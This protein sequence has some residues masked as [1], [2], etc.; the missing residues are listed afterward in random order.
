MPVDP[1]RFRSHFFR[2]VGAEDIDPATVRDLAD[3]AAREDLDGLGF[4]EPAARPGDATAA[5]FA[6]R[7]CEA[8]TVLAAREPLVPAGLVFAPLLLERFDPRL[9]FEPLAEDGTRIAQGVLLGRIRGPADTLLTAER[10]LLNFL[11][12]LSGIATATRRLVDLMGDSPTRLLDTRKT[13]PGYRALAKYAFASGGGWNHRLGLHDRVMLKDN[14][15][16][17]SRLREAGDFADALATIR[18]EHPHLPV[19][20]EIDRLGQLDAVLAAA[21]EAVLLDNF[22]PEQLREAVARVDGRCL[23]EASG[24][25]TEDTLPALAR[26]GL[27]FIST[28]AGVHR[29]RW[30][31]IGMD[32]EGGDRDQQ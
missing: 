19:Q 8:T 10:T 4:L 11:Q 18:Q 29:A 5:L 31:D 21:P 30:T 1:D 2:R 16:G 32:L 15:L 12:M 17:A 20:I 25:V 24:G 28:G 14:H 9:V 27:D 3:R 26:L 6:E 22:S 7:H 23:T 13:P